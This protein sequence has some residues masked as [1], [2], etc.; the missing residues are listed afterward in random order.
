MEWLVVVAVLLLI[1]FAFLCRH[2]LWTKH[3]IAEREAAEARIRSFKL[4][5][6]DNM[7]GLSFEHYV[8][9]LLRHEGFNAVEVTK[10][11]GDFGVDIIASQENCRHAI[12]VKR[13]SRTI[14]RRA[15][16][17]AVA[18]KSHYSCD[19]A[20]VITNNYLS[21]PARG[22]AR[23]VGCK[24]INRDILSEWIMRLQAS[25]SSNRML[26]SVTQQTKGKPKKIDHRKK[27]DRISYW[28]P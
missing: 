16:S 17:D 6:I 15:V 8:A 9:K 23:S 25:E 28:E 4:S 26:H 10:G 24:I 18:G 14:S 1:H 3:Y 27:S 19:S 11:S 2:K 5:D 22:F 13:S 20:M 7:D 21:K 12:Q